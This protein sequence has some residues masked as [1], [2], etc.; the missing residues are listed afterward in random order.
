MN[1]VVSREVWL[2]ARRALLAR[3]KEATHLRDKV[4]AERLALPW[5]K[6]EKNYVFDTPDGKKTLARSLR[7]SQPADDLSLHARPRL[8]G[9]LPG[10]LVPRRPFRRRAAA[11]QP[12]RRHAGRGLARA[13]RRRST[14]TSG[15][16]AGISPGSPSFGSDFNFDYHVSFTEEE[17]PRDKVFYNFTAI[18]AGMRPTTNC[19]ASAPSTRTRRATSSTPIRATPA[20]RK[21]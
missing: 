1:E 11:S 15:A 4:N 21:R 5:V 20:G 6:V 2:E 17:L 16:W 7:W 8:G 18:D 10:L 13:A 12:S 14:P 3:E 19:R 9:R